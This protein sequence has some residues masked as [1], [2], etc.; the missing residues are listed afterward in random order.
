MTDPF[1]KQQRIKAPKMPSLTMPKAPG[2]M[3]GFK[4]PSFSTRPINN[5]AMP[6][7]PS[8]NLGKFTKVKIPK[9]TKMAVLKKAVKNVGF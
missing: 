9:M 3:T 7:A 2:A 4:Q 1:L 5:T 8:V 6:A